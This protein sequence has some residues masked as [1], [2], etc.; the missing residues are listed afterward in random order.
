MAS[1]SKG[2]TDVTSTSTEIVAANSLRNGVI[3][4]NNGSIDVYLGLGVDA[5]D[6]EGICVPAGGSATLH[7]GGEPSG[8]YN[9]FVKAING[10]AASGTNSVA[11]QEI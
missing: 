10:I 11:Y 3:L 8:A 4:K 2:K 1:A 9:E 5:V 6:Q 7:Y